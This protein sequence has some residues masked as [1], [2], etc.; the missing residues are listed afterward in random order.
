[1]V[2]Q[3]V[4]IRQLVHAGE[5]IE[6]TSWRRGS[7]FAKAQGAQIRTGHVHSGLP[8]TDDNKDDDHDDERNQ[9]GN[10]RP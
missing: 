3:H 4:G 1:M 8:S 10:E 9:G 5:P 7:T 6:N 2:L